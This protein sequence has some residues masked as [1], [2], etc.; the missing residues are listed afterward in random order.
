MSGP[1]L[2]K[3]GKL[4]TQDTTFLE[5]WQSHLQT[6]V[7]SEATLEEI[8]QLLVKGRSKALDKMMYV[9]DFLMNLVTRENWNKDAQACLD[10]IRDI[11]NPKKKSSNKQIRINREYLEHLLGIILWYTGQSFATDEFWYD[12]VHDISVRIETKVSKLSKY[13]DSYWEKMVP[14]L[15]AERYELVPTK[16]QIVSVLG[17]ILK[18]EFDGVRLNAVFPRDKGIN[19][20]AII[21]EDLPK[22]YLQLFQNTYSQSSSE[23]KE[24]FINMLIIA[25][26]KNFL[27][28]MLHDHFTMELLWRVCTNNMS[29][30][31]SLAWVIMMQYRK[32]LESYQIAVS[33]GLTMLSVT[34]DIGYLRIFK[35]VAYV[36]SHFEKSYKSKLTFT[37]KELSKPNAAGTEGATQK[38]KV[39]VAKKP[40]HKVVTQ[41]VQAVVNEADS[42]FGVEKM[43]RGVTEQMPFEVFQPWEYLQC[44]QA[45]GAPALK[46]AVITLLDD[47]GIKISDPIGDETILDCKEMNYHSYI[48]WW[49]ILGHEDVK[50]TFRR[51]R[52]KEN[53]VS[54]KFFAFY[55][56]DGYNSV[57]DV[58][59][60]HS[61][62]EDALNNSRP[63]LTKGAIQAKAAEVPEVGKYEFRSVKFDLLPQDRKT[64]VEFK[65]KGLSTEAF[66]NHKKQARLDDFVSVAKAQFP[67][68]EVEVGV[69]NL[70]M[71]PTELVT[72]LAKD[73]VHA[74]TGNQRSANASELEALKSMGDVLSRNHFQAVISH[75]TENG[76]FSES[77]FKVLNSSWE[78]LRKANI[79]SN[80]IHFPALLE[81]IQL[82][83]NGALRRN[84]Y[85]SLAMEESRC[86]YGTNDIEGAIEGVVDNWMEEIID[87]SVVS[88]AVEKSD[89]LLSRL[90][91][92][93]VSFADD[94]G[95]VSSATPPQDVRNWKIES[96]EDTKKSTVNHL[97]QK[98][99]QSQLNQVVK[100]GKSL[101]MI[102]E[103]LYPQMAHHKYEVY[104]AWQYILFKAI[105]V[106][107]KA[108]VDD[109]VNLGKGSP[110]GIQQMLKSLEEHPSLCINY[111]CVTVDLATTIRIM[112]GKL[113]SAGAIAFSLLQ[114]SSSDSGKYDAMLAIGEVC[115]QR[116]N[117][118]NIAAFFGKFYA[119]VEKA[120]GLGRA[121]GFHFVKDSDTI[122][123]DL[124]AIQMMLCMVER[125]ARNQRKDGSIYDAQCLLETHETMAKKVQNGT[126]PSTFAAFIDEFVELLGKTV[127]MGKEE[128]GESKIGLAARVKPG[129][130]STQPE[131]QDILQ[132]NKLFEMIKKLPS[133]NQ[134]L[135]SHGGGYILKK[136]DKNG[137]AQLAIIP[138][139]LFH[140]IRNDKQLKRQFDQL[141]VK[142]SVFHKLPR[143]PKKR[144][145][146]ADEDDAD[147]PPQNNSKIHAK[148]QRLQHQKQPSAPEDSSEDSSSEP[149]SKKGKHIK[150]SKPKGGEFVTLE[151][152][153][154]ALSGYFDRLAPAPTASTEGQS[155]AAAAAPSGGAGSKN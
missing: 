120:N 34:D 47:G 71:V 132:R 109:N 123:S 85:N 57:S 82:T 6:L 41:V 8:V 133:W 140:Q 22:S 7:L 124:V 121:T 153:N 154:T 126:A 50:G 100:A 61:T 134:Y 150:Q 58:T 4:S 135:Q 51:L 148:K 20:G 67:A 81:L 118:E 39:D 106:I 139:D 48:Q 97:L 12:A 104:Q 18:Y 151:Q 37:L 27:V 143:F 105:K 110:L 80:N 108:L 78:E 16:K 32:H 14:L 95:L 83:A 43:L 129:S 84:D 38:E 28:S 66:H 101:S 128:E 117:G 119:L 25:S 46:K 33:D 152:L 92:L 68:S 21:Y 42:G 102:M 149:L 36:L 24:Y 93:V 45:M 76:E 72:P 29:G 137:T 23:L 113:E 64:W 88:K 98:N 74:L 112:S 62:I 99:H 77:G 13:Y 54:K 116:Y 53:E 131:Q 138:K 127:F 15:S 11:L 103:I 44:M 5:S 125:S 56:E 96:K 63:I 30:D 144:P 17:D 69:Q 49:V 60:D 91:L 19:G 111:A 59:G 115:S 146:E 155:N 147:V 86:M 136:V 122:I 130:Q 2:F 31:N 55:K 94:K 142:S 114:Q 70:S 141:K 9:K 79:L 65:Q 40:V 75:I 3:F 52:C 145:K 87:D 10:Q 73:S 89:S 26:P 90:G 35:P 1:L 107:V